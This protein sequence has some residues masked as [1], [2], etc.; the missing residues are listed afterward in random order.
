[1]KKWI[2]AILTLV[3]LSQTL[4]WTAF[5]ATGN[6]ITEAELKR[7]L[8]IAGLQPETADNGGIRA[9]FDAKSN[10]TAPLRLEAKES[11]YHPGMSP[12]ET[13]DAQ[14]MLDWLDHKLFRDI[15]NVTNVF[16]RAETI[17][18][19]MKDEDPAAYAHFTDGMAYDAAFQGKCHSMVL[20]AEA[21]EEEARYFRRRIQENMVVIEQ[22]TETLS[23]AQGQLFDFETA[24]LSE[25]IREATDQL[26][27]LREEM[28]VFAGFQVLTIMSAQKMI[29]GEIEPGFSAWLKEVL[30]SEDG[31]QKVTVSADAVVSTG[32]STRKS[33]MAAGER[34]LANVG[35][36]DV[37]VQVI[38]EN[39]FVIVLQGVDNQYVGGVK[40]TVKDLN[41]NAVSTMT[42]EAEFGSAVF[43]ANDFVC[44]FDKEME[45]SLEVDA[46]AQG[47]RS[48]CIPWLIVKRGGSRTETLTP[49]TGPEEQTNA[50]IGVLAPD[51]ANASDFKPYIYACTFNGYDI[52]KQDQSTTISKANDASIDF[53]VEVEHPSA[54]KPTAPVLHCWM[55]SSDKLYIEAKTFNPTA[56]QR[57]SANRTRYTY[58]NTW[59]RDLSPDITI[60]Q[61]DP[62]KDQ[63]P[64][65]I[66]PDTKEKVQTTLVPVRAK[67]DQP[68]ITGQEPSNPLN[69]VLGKGFGLNIDI[70]AIG[71]KLSFNLPFDKYLPKINYNPV[72]YLTVIFGASGL[73]DPN[74]ASLWKSKEA[75]SYDKAM[76]KFEHEGSLAKQKQKLGTASNYYKG[77]LATP[78]QARLNLNFGYFLML[79]GRAQMDDNGTSV[80]SVSG[81]GGGEL[82]LSFDYTQMMQV[83]IVPLYL[84][85]NFSASAGICLEGL[86]FTW[87]LDENAKPDGFDWW[88]LRGVTINIRLAVSISLGIGIKGVCSAWVSATGG[89]NII[90]TIMNGM[91]AHVAVYGEFFVS[92]GFE[93]FW[94]KY[95][96]VVWQL[97]K[98]LI[99]ANHNLDDPTKNAA[100]PL[101][102]ALADAP[103]SE[104]LELTKLE[105]ERY[106]SLA[107]EAKKVLSNAANV[108]A[109][110]K[111]AELKGH[112]YVFYIGESRTNDGYTSRNI[113]WIEPATGKTGIVEDCCDSE[114][115]RRYNAYAFDVV[116]N[117]SLLA[118]VGN[119][120][121]AFTESGYPK[122]N[123]LQTY[124]SYLYAVV[125]DYSEYS[126]NLSNVSDS[127]YFSTAVTQYFTGYN[128][129]LQ[130]H[131][132]SL[133]GDPDKANETLLLT[134][135]CD[136]LY[137]GTG[138]KGCITFEWEG[139]KLQTLGDFTVKN[140]LGDDHERIQT[141]SILNRDDIDYYDKPQHSSFAGKSP[142]GSFIALSKPKEGVA[143][144]SA[145]ELFD[146]F[147][148]VA[149]IEYTIDKT[150][151]YNP[152]WKITKSERRAVALATGDIDHME[153]VVETRPDGTID[154]RTV[155][156]TETET[157]GGRAQ[158]RLKSL[159]FQP[160][161]VL[162]MDNFK[163]D[164]SY[165]D[166]DVSL[167]DAQFRA[168]T[169]GASR[170]LYW[171]NTVSREEGKES[172][173]D[174]WRI[175]GVYYDAAAN[176][177]SDQ[178]VIAEF[179]L[180]N[181]TWNG[182]TYRS[183]PYEVT[184][185]NSGTG[186]I[187]AKPYTGNEGD[188]AIAPITL[189]S[190]P[191]TLKPVA[192][193]TGA[194]LMETTV[195]QGDFV[196]TDLAVMN[197]GNMG[198]GSFDVEL[199]LMSE[200]GKREQKKIETLHADCLNP[201]NSTLVLHTGERDET[202]AQGEAAFYRLKDFEYSPRQHEW[203]VKSQDRTVN[204]RDGKNVTTT[205][206]GSNFNRLVTNVLVPGALGGFTGSIKIPAD[207]T[208]EKRLRLKL[209]RESTYANWMAAVA[210][211]NSHPE[212][213]TESIASDRSTVATN[214]AD[215]ALAKLGIHKLVYELDEDG[216]K[217]VLQ[218]PQAAILANANDTDEMLR[219]YPMEIEA[220]EPIEI[221]CDVHDIDVGHRLW[222]DIYGE[223]ML[224]III[225][226]YHTT[227]EAI[228]LT[229]AIY[230][231]NSDTPRYVSLPYDPNV[232]SAGKTT[233]ITLPLKVFIP[234]ADEHREARVV[235]TGRGIQET[236][237]VNNEFTLYL[238]G[239]ALHFVKEP[240]DVTV[241]E[242]EDVSFAV[243]VA[244]GKPSYTYQW[245]VW[246]EKHQKWVDLPGF[247]NPTLSREDIEK[248]WDGVKFRCVVTDAEGTKIISREVTLTV[249]DGVDT[250]DHSNLPL[251]LAI[252]LAAL[253]LL[254]W[255]RRRIS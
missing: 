161:T 92:V 106:S 184:L 177:V 62:S 176:T 75:Q 195:C 201:A 241:Q 15:Y 43:N 243:E 199:W 122:G 217:L 65:F 20:D 181:A 80:W 250:G 117:G 56:T 175:T 129:I 119:C 82:V 87:R 208:G 120:A 116:S 173:P 170:Y 7:A 223:A 137:D 86:Y 76:K 59:K 169:L 11:G 238:G 180:P 249:R 10:G 17:L 63:R 27:S 38:T 229:C 48:F 232:L 68:I 135:S 112:T 107:P 79:S 26:E 251:Y 49:L 191:I 198:I 225:N 237:S 222:A 127:S 138:E 246:D 150:D 204:V 94:I 34:I 149:P 235:I 236:A 60:S 53:V 218:Q 203:I 42:T 111:V 220:P 71:G 102:T 174:I 96:K 226:N 28:L 103:E 114:Y 67:V 159:S 255:V 25:Q 242:G 113:N 36:E 21:V 197:E 39:D 126:G 171:L 193:L 12:N 45:I 152:I 73:K 35:S 141:G 13:W 136:A 51:A 123:T 183:V 44:D 134:G 202:V 207:W 239:G 70:P 46:S 54:A 74:D 78:G 216:D 247:T 6:M 98:W 245:Q 182:K 233:T 118:V 147:M 47:Y 157:M 66:L 133:S 101:L 89:L 132:D 163:Y 131:I 196:A 209:T 23:E 22:N 8:L 166:Y 154:R 227:Q 214:A 4:P 179:S 143:G 85:V 93:I 14:Q 158:H 188:H 221:K 206:S 84:N 165:S 32:Y 121:N 172:V 77:I 109:D 105:P 83:G 160:K 244:G 194:A 30:D 189:Y 72:G 29:D 145:I 97:P 212:L 200:D 81:G 108:Q 210:L 69:S 186:Y 219:L 230:L 90:L 104:E 168:V 88:L 50:N 252:A 151:K 16:T 100:Q 253:I 130:P 24:R 58:T 40:V 18:E 57:I 2:A 95:S 5:A 167:P 91:P 213:F 125:M 142:S 33:R 99:W 240:E 124:A 3:M 128:V 205:D 187:S 55:E 19:K 156:Y 9:L 178:I 52:M 234:D 190:F 41:G 37:S 144:K 248:K 185:T 164:L 148:N 31:Q 254:W 61:D 228:E 215:D 139:Y 140:A 110:I 211:A 231:D 155:F 1:M 192:N 224:D 146:I 162:G 115:I 153:M 64:Y